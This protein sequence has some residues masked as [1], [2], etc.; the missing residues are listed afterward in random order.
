MKLS[1]SHTSKEENVESYSIIISIVR[2]AS[3][4]DIALEMKE[5]YDPAC[6]S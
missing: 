1:H 6:I 3:L 5:A 4:I 2:F